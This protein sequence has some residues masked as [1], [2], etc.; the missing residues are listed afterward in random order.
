MSGARPSFRRRRPWHTERL[1]MHEEDRYG[2]DES[3]DIAIIGMAGRFPGAPDIASFWENLRA[4][5]DAGG[6]LGDA[7]IEAAGIPPAMRQMPNFVPAGAQ[8]ENI[9]W[10]DGSFFGYS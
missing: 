3:L 2:S 10:F 5:G 8:L 7:E 6:R 9:E 4:G 1:P